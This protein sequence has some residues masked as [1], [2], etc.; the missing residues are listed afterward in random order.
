[1]SSLQRKWAEFKKADESWKEVGQG[2][3]FAGTTAWRTSASARSGT[4]SPTASP[5]CAACFDCSVAG[6]YQ[7]TAGGQMASR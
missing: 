2:L 1:V 3:L 7:Q 5:A 6:A 4:F